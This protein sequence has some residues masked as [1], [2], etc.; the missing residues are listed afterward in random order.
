MVGPRFP[1][2]HGEIA[3]NPPPIRAPPIREALFLALIAAKGAAFFASFSRSDVGWCDSENGLSFAAI[4]GQ[5]VGP[6]NSPRF[7]IDFRAF[8]G[9]SRAIRHQSTWPSFWTLIA[10]KDDSFLAHSSRYDIGWE[11]TPKMGY[12]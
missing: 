5:N 10:A 7:V 2:D 9:K 6:V 4:R 12:P 3:A 1:G 8:A 11:M